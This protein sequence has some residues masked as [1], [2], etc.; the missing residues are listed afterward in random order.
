MP[1]SGLD[2]ADGSVS[3]V[4]TPTA[5]GQ[6][7]VVSDSTVLFEELPSSPEIEFGE[8]A[9]IT[10]SFRTT[11][12]NAIIMSLGLS[13]G[14]I[15]ID[16]AGYA[17]R[18]LNTRI[19]KQPGDL[20]L[21]TTTAEGINFDNPPDEFE[22]DIIEI[23][24]ELE[25]LPRYSSVLKY[26]VDV[27]TG[28]AVNTAIDTGPVIINNARNVANAASLG[29]SGES[30]GTLNSSRIPDASVLTLANELVRK[31]QK[32]IDTFYMPG[33]HIQWS[34]FY[35]YPPVV[36]GG[37]YREDPIQAGGLPSI[38]W[39]DTSLPGG[40]NNLYGALGTYNPAIYSGGISWLRQ[41]DR[42]LFQRTWHRL[43]RS[44]IGGPL[45]HWDTDI[46]PVY[47]PNSL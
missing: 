12:Q 25:K 9:T 14:T 43:T 32:H 31:Y 5:V 40:T 16:D 26:N 2:W 44:W 33:F 46:Y 11:Y 35:F 13:R 1:P 47:D 30:F 24:P 6:K 42:I 10:H 21:L 23:N 28:L 20:A 39:S 3:G 38:Y 41:A 19:T 34:Q 45:G 15:L 37:I 36:N 22:M 17:T 8:Q 27:T 7:K 18:I 4:G 29:Q